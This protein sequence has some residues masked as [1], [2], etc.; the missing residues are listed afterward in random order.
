MKPFSRW[1]FNGIASI[2]LLLFV[3]MVA[4]W[5]RGSWIGDTFNFERTTVEGKDGSKALRGCQGYVV[6]SGIWID[7]VIERIPPNREVKPGA[8]WRHD[9]VLPGSYLYASDVLRGLRSPQ[10]TITRRSLVHLSR[11]GVEW[12]TLKW[13]VPGQTAATHLTVAVPLW[14]LSVLFL[15]FPLAWD[16][17]HRR[18][19]R[20]LGCWH[21]GRCQVCGY[22]L[23]ATPDRCP[24]C[25]KIPPKTEIIST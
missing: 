25:G 3:A 20:A 12:T 22:D 16:I 18:R 11:F 1:L 19:H 6:G 21:E 2:S 7:C 9:Y 24:E 23:R 14:F 13:A 5:V 15:M 4:L 10:L 17:G 8:F